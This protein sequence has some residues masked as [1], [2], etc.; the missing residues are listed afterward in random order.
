VA[1]ILTALT[2]N[3]YGR[4]WMLHG[5]V[6]S[7]DGNAATDAIVVNFSDFVT[8]PG[9]VINNVTYSALKLTH[10]WAT[11]ANIGAPGVWTLKFDADT[12]VVITE[13]PARASQYYDFTLLP[14]GGIP[15]PRGTNYT[16]DITID[17]GGTGVALDVMGLVMCGELI[18]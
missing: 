14:M 9:V 16:G 7:D 11:G 1:T 18:P 8:S 5:K 6:H 10:M 3:L 15:D 12:P 17:Y 4:K 13:L 2:K